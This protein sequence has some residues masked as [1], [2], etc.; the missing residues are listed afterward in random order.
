MAPDFTLELLD[1]GEVTLSDLRGQVV[2][3]NLWASWCPPC[4]EEMPA[5]QNVYN[6]YQARGFTVIALNTTYQD[7]EREASEFIEEMGL[8]FPVAL[9]RTGE[10][11]R[12]YLLRALPTTFFID[13]EGV[14]QKVV[15]GGPMSE[16]LI[17]STVEALLPENE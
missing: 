6:R 11:S 3:L 8:S 9:D 15:V 16:A 2:L 7:G 14:I 5:I 12:R 10:V 1:G 13:T 4:R 17:R